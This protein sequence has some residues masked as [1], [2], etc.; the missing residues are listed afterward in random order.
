MPL[1][2]TTAT[3][4]PV[5][6][7]PL[8]QRLALTRMHTEAHLKAAQARLEC[9]VGIDRIKANENA[10]R[11]VTN[12]LATLDYAIEAIKQRDALAIALR[13]MLAHPRPHESSGAM[14][15]ERTADYARRYRGYEAAW[16]AAS[17]L[18]Q[19]IGQ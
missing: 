15:D 6:S 3:Q 12:A 8:I 11:T 9:E 5:E 14:S 17:K 7:G 16:D 1:N 4:K 10:V 2:G 18:M 19:G 13:D